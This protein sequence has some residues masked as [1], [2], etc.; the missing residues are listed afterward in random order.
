MPLIHVWN[1]SPSED[2]TAQGRMPKLYYDL[3]RACMSVTELGIKDATDVLI[4]N[5]GAAICADPDAKTA[6]ALVLIVDLL[7]DKPERTIEIKRKLAEAIGRAAHEGVG[8]RRP[9][10]VFV[11]TFNPQ[12]E[13]SWFSNG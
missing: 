3:G 11:R 8:T 7:Y 10:E 1:Y 13:A 9:I 12:T 4:S 2:G 6:A 5:H